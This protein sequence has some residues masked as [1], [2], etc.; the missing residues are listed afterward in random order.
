M[1]RTDNHKQSKLQ[2]L[3]KEDR[4]LFHSRDLALLWEIDNKNT[5]YTSIKRYVKKG[6]LNPIHK[7]F[8]STIS[9]DRFDPF[10]LGVS[11]LHQ[12][13]YISTETVLA[14][15]GIIQQD[16]NYITLVSSLSKKFS[17]GEQRYFC[18]KMKDKLLY[19]GMGIVDKSNYKEAETE[20][21]VADLLYFNPN[22]YFDNAG[23]IDWEKVKY[24]QRKAGFI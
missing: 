10:S 22:Y 5:L 15:A 6:I 1:Y 19:Q 2:I 24:I 18:R 17:I 3:L 11:F 4:K 13:A 9:L 20:R 8:Y 23:Q 7:G 12:Y 14:R 21:A 16:L